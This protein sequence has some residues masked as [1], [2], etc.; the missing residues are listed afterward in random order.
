MR[1]KVFGRKL[2]RN[3]KSRKALFR[4][5]ARGMILEGKI[6]TTKAKAKATVPMLEK[7]MT[8]AIKA[9]LA[10]TKAVVAKLGGDKQ[11][12][13][14]LTKLA[15]SVGKKNSGF[16]RVTLLP[17]RKGDN[18]QMV[19]MEWTIKPEVEKPVKKK[20]AEKK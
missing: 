2:G 19:E 11:L 4:S 7:L 18:A 14:K 20:E 1:K 9:D 3:T 13:Q 5:L 15:K 12:A 17:T 8:K 16:T 6:V 10:S